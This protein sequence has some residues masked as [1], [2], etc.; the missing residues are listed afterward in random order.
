MDLVFKV[1]SMN[2]PK[3]LGS[4]VA[5]TSLSLI[6]RVKAHDEDAWRR[7]VRLY[8]PLV[9]FWVRRAGL[10]AAD[11]EDVSQEVFRSVAGNISRFHKDQPGDSFRA[12]LRTVTR[13]KVIDHVRRQGP[14]PRAVGGS[15]AQQQLQE[16]PA[17]PD[18]EADESREVQWL[19]RRAL[20]LVQAQFEDRTWQMVW[21]VTVDD[22]AV[23]DVA[24]D[25]GV[26]PAAVRLAKSRVLRRLREELAGLEP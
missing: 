6:E 22:R 26:T 19:H 3:K 5:S 24:R 16:R 23:N 17:V 4:S 20:E 14:E 11:A 10:H 25:F 9:D 18:S 21:Q 8:G 2:S 1:V 15:A 13:N 7:L 12:W